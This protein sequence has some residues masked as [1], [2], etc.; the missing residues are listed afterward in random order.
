MSGTVRPKKLPTRGEPLIRQIFE[1]MN[2]RKLSYEFVE[3]RSGKG[4]AR[5][6]TWRRRG[7]AA[8]SGVVAVANA[9]G[10]D[11]VLVE[12]TTR[13]EWTGPQE[14]ADGR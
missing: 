8:L 10:Y 9:M 11:V 6:L 7:G 2:H 4:R 12:R 3:E 1:V 5:L 14:P 13:K